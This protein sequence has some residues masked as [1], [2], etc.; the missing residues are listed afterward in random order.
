MIKLDEK[1]WEARIVTPAL[2]ELENVSKT[3][4]KGKASKL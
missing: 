2:F 3:Y 1:V 4:K